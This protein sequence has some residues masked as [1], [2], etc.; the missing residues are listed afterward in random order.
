M[1]DA[2]ETMPT[3]EEKIN[4]TVASLKAVLTNVDPT[5]IEKAKHK[6]CEV[7]LAEAVDEGAASTADAAQGEPKAEGTTEPGLS[8]GRRS[9][10][11]RQKKSA[12]KSKKGGRSRKNGSKNRRKHSRRR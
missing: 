1:A 8:G 2:Q 5:I 6:F 9:R 11:R 10:R 12:K 3:E 7:P 4:Q